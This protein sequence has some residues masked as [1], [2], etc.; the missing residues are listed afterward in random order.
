[1]LKNEIEILLNISKDSLLSFTKRITQIVCG[2]ILNNSTP[3]TWAAK[4]D[5]T[6]KYLE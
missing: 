4:Q 1:M 2:D 6:S 5:E 3:N